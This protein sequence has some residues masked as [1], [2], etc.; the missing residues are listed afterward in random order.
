MWACMNVV[1]NSLQFTMQR[2]DQSLINY[3]RPFDYSAKFL[4]MSRVFKR[5]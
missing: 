3:S 2:M 4:M 5:N 1:V